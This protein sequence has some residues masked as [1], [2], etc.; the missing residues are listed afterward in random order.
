MKPKTTTLILTAIFAIMLSIVQCHSVLSGCRARI[1]P[2]AS[3]LAGVMGDLCCAASRGIA[4]ANEGRAPGEVV[5]AIPSGCL[6]AGLDLYG[7]VARVDTISKFGDVP[8]LTGF[9]PASREPGTSASSPEAFLGI[10]IVEAFAMTPGLAGMLESVDLRELENPEVVL[11]TETVVRLGVGNYALK[12]ERLREVLSQCV[13]LG[14]KPTLIDL[15]FRDQ[16]VVRPG[17]IK[18]KTDREV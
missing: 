17:T 18:R 15:R 16:V 1:E 6:A 11:R 12:L 9:T 10:T 14:M 7:Y 13:L 3:R 8:L 4:G 5:A 2:F